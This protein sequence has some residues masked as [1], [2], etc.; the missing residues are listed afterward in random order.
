MP[1]LG[2]FDKIEIP[3]LT[4]KFEG[5]VDESMP[6]DKQREIGAKIAL[7]YHKQLNDELNAFQKKI[8]IKKTSEYKAPD[9]S[10]KIKQ[11]ND[12][13]DALAEEEKRKNIPTAPVNKLRIRH[14]TSEEDLDNVVSGQSQTPLARQAI[15][16]E[17]PKLIEDLKDSGQ[18]VK[19][20]YSSDLERGAD[21]A[22]RV[23]DAMGAEHIIDK[24]LRSWDL[25]DFS[26]TD[27]G[28]FKPIQ[29]WFVDNPD[30]TEYNGPNKKFQGKKIGESFNEYKDRAIKAEQSIPDEEGTI[31]MGHSNNMA[32]NEA[33]EAHG[34]WT[35]E[36]KEQYLKSKTPEPAEMPDKKPYKTGTTDEETAALKEHGEEAKIW[37]AANVEDL[38]SGD[39]IKKE[40]KKLNIHE[41]AKATDVT[42]EREAAGEN[43]KPVHPVRESDQAAAKSGER[44]G[45]A[46]PAKPAP[47]DVKPLPEHGET[48]GGVDVQGKTPAELQSGAEIKKG[49]KEASDQNEKIKYARKNSYPEYKKK[50]PEDDIETYNVNRGSKP[51]PKLGKKATGTPDQYSDPVKALQ[52]IRDEHPNDPLIQRTADFLEPIMKAS[53]AIHIENADLPGGYLGLAHADGRVQIDFSAHE[54]TEDAHRTILHELMHAA[55]RYEI[56]HNEAFQTEVRKQLESIRKALKL[57]E[58][59]VGDVLIPA[60]VQRGIIPAEK[61]GTSNVHELLAEVFSNQKFNDLLRSLKS[62]DGKTNLLQQVFN[63]I[64]KFFNQNYKALSNL[65]DKIGSSDMA[66][67]LMKLTEGTIKKQGKADE[68]TLAKLEES[69]EDRNIKNV[70]SRISGTVPEDEVF[71]AIK[72]ATGLEDE[73]IHQ[74]MKDAGYT[75]KKLTNDAAGRIVEGHTDEQ[76]LSYLKRKGLDAD[77][78]LAVLGEAKKNPIDPEKKKELIEQTKKQA[79]DTIDKWEGAKN[80]NKLEAGKE[81]RENQQAIKKATPKGTDWK[82]VD[83]AIHLYND[84]KA[85]TKE[86]YDEL[87]NSIDPK[88]HGK[89]LK[90][91]ELSENLTDKQKE[92]ADQ[93]RDKYKEIG[94]FALDNEVI[95][96]LTEN[97]VGR[98][99]DKGKRPTE[100]GTKFGTSTR[101][102]LQ[103]TLGSIMEGYAEGM[104]LKIEGASNNLQTVQEEVKNVVENRVLLEKML[105][106]KMPDGTRLL[107]THPEEGYVKIENPSFAKWKSA[108]NLKDYEAED[109]QTFGKRRDVMVTENGQVLRKEPVYAPTD[110]A[111]SLNNIMG[112]S[113]LAGPLQGITKF[114]A[115][116]KKTIL[117]ASA[118]HY[119]AF[120]RVHELSGKNINPI[121]IVNTIKAYR[122]GLNMISEKL[123]ELKELVTD[124]GLTL[125]RGQDWKE[126]LNDHQS[127]LGKQADKLAVTK[128]VK[129][130]ILAFNEAAHHTLFETFGAGLKSFDAVNMFRN[131]LIKNPNLSRKEVASNVAM[132]MNDSYGG[133]NWNRMHGS[134]LQNPTY[135]HVLSLGM[136]APDWTA[137]NIRFAKNGF[138]GGYEGQVYRKLAAKVILRGT[139]ATLAANSL[140]ALFDEQDDDGNQLSWWESMERRYSKAWDAG[141]LRFLNV[142]VTPLYQWAGGDPEKRAYFNIFGAYTDPIKALPKVDPGAAVSAV[143]GN[144]GDL[145]KILDF[146]NTKQFLENKTSPLS[147]AALEAFTG[148]NW[149]KRPFTSIDELLGTDDK[150]VYARDQ[151]G[152]KK[153]E[154]KN[155]YTGEKYIR[156]I[157]PHFAGEEKGGKFGGM[158]TRTG[159]PQGRLLTAGQTPSFVLSQARGML[160]VAAQNVLQ[161]GTGENDWVSSIANAVGLQ[162]LT[163]KDKTLEKK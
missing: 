63:A 101:H 105:K 134:K 43:A 102:S 103:R 151:Q 13:Y 124:G 114:N 1:K 96:E 82:D 109:K 23:A 5:M 27:D 75:I 25:K 6:E 77:N 153:G 150:G 36:A 15:E 17:I 97:Y 24:N 37:V 39:D 93:I 155:E 4:Q 142:D 30:E 126:G 20:I 135:R 55:T 53:P 7:D 66:E 144:V 146:E 86:E 49:L 136:L 128:A 3:E 111:K 157:Q 138:K 9:N 149:Q 26:K 11:V 110:I 85:L 18:P 100:L 48:K 92:I 160:P 59:D 158:L 121:P 84:S 123:P 65:R 29:K 58:G 113:K 161:A 21:T 57:P 45:G 107:Q 67:Y 162:I 73:K 64:V 10:A 132:A 125:T 118:F 16:E 76:I 99:W 79:F 40:I 33:S 83:K 51:M 119:V 34:G 116:I 88:T 80:W 69:P 72:D 89:E 78:A 112:S 8:G 133:I 32:I 52:A 129:D 122:E 50:F 70:I 127:W 87:K 163:N 31:V 71:K 148:T 140:M 81:A 62:T 60:L 95:H 141:R 152:H 44:T 22:K 54:S 41:P 130:K 131:Q 42:G 47:G 14:G 19:K 46:K 143:S 139:A 98:T 120:T 2:C 145:S 38:F 91:I 159:D 35:P 147:K 12:K 137:S 154:V 90:I 115:E 106:T 56:G 156:D 28:E 104:H 61:Y 74:L 68:A 94:D 108:G 117:S